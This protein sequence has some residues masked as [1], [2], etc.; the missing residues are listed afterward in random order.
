[1]LLFGRLG[2]SGLLIFGALGSM[3]ITVIIER[4]G[5]ECVCCLVFVV[6]R[7][8]GAWVSRVLLLGC[9]GFESCCCLALC[10]AF[11]VAGA[12]GF[13]FVCFLVVCFECLCCLRAGALKIMCLERLLWFL[14]CWG[15]GFQGLLSF[16][17]LFFECFRARL[18]F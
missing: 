1:M 18:V 17:C 15:F 11:C 4:F 3:I 14:L 16:G 6:L 10:C 5:F 12:L 13:T 9:L 7:F 2:F 8:A